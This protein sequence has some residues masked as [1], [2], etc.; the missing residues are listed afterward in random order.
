MSEQH[1]RSELTAEL[2]VGGF[3]F[4]ILLVIG[5]FTIVLSREN[6]FHTVYPMEI[7][8]R[9]V[10]GLR[11]GDN[12]VVRGMTVG[13]VKELQLASDRVRVVCALDSQVLLKKNY[14]ISIIQ[15]SI[16]GGRMLQIDAGTDAAE[17]LPEGVKV[18]GTEPFDLMVEAALTV[19]DIRKALSDGKVLENMEKIVAELRVTTEKLNRNEGTLGKL[20]NED[21]VYTNLQ[22]LLSDGR[23][24]VAAIKDTVARINGG[25]GTL[26]K[27][28]ADETV[29]TNL[30]A[31]SDNLKAV[32]DRLVQGKGTLGRLLSSDDALYKDIADAAASLKSIAARLDK[33]EGTLGKLLQSDELYKQVK[34]TIEEARAAVDDFRETAPITTF[35]S[36]LFGAF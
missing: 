32:S 1:N 27:L 8:F 26:G 14:K 35:T 24:A 18:I 20:L 19:H 3:M 9:D 6:I 31:I 5:Y 13:K 12:V 29:Y 23:S 4:L 17:P 30:V 16:L 2:I 21:G 10:M 28:I 15:T 25:E 22:Q 7:E 33:G 36:I 34:G 11:D